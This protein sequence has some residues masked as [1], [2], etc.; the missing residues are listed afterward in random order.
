MMEFDWDV[1]THNLFYSLFSLIWRLKISLSSGVIRHVFWLRSFMLGWFPFRLQMFI[2]NW[3]SLVLLSW[4]GNESFQV[5]LK[6]LSKDFFLIG[7]K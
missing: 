6:S 2:W 1:K 3:I 7:F 5:I 4:F